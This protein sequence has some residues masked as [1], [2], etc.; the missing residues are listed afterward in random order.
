ME[1]HKL[2]VLQ[3]TLWLKHYH[4]YYCLNDSRKKAYRSVWGGVAEVFRLFHNKS[5]ERTTLL[6]I[7]V[8]IVFTTV[9][10]LNQSTKPFYFYF[11]LLISYRSVRIHFTL[12][13]CLFWDNED[14]LCTPALVSLSAPDYHLEES[15]SNT[16]ITYI[17]PSFIGFESIFLIYCLL[18]FNFFL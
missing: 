3:N 6:Y 4:Y 15:H 1:Y 14:L 13:L 12:T 7:Y 10:I 5:R 2:K 17:C 18:I 11:T 9:L 8:Y 16:A